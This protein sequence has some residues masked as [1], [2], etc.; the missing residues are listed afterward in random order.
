[1]DA[2]LSSN[3]FWTCYSCKEKNDDS[4]HFCQKCEKQR[5]PLTY[6]YIKYVDRAQLI[7]PDFDFDEVFAKEK[8]MLKRRGDFEI[9][10]VSNFEQLLNEDFQKWYVISIKWIKN[11]K[12]FVN[13][14]KDY[15]G[16]I[17]NSDLFEYNKQTKALQIRPSLE[18]NV[19]Y[20]AVNENIWY[21]LHT[22]YGGGPIINRVQKSLYT[23][24]V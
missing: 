23:S 24:E 14:Q 6:N 17:D 22:F 16:P 8:Q 5:S 20:K 9:Q 1:M 10:L 4:L 3:S 18:R 12:N 15:P 21:V 19:D 2:T 7:K 13:K 11:W